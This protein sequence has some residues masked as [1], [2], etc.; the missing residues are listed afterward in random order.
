M[1]QRAQRDVPAGE[2]AKAVILVALRCPRVGGGELADVVEAGR[3]YAGK[4]GHVV[5]LRAMIAGRTR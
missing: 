3:R 4:A 1:G 2:L 5:N